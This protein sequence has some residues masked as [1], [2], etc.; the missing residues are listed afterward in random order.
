MRGP[1]PRK[2]T[3]PVVAP[4]T[5][6]SLVWRSVA[7]SEMPGVNM[8]EASGERTYF[9]GK[10]DADGD[11]CAEPLLTGHESYDCY[12]YEFTSARPIP[13][14]LVIFFGEVDDLGLIRCRFLRYVWLELY[15]RFILLVFSVTVL[16]QG[17][18]F[19]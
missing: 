17:R 14:V 10:L 2:T 1:M 16:E 13:W 18:A 9:P 8:L 7:I 19:I 5:V 4:T 3:K 11:G 6:L 15:L 12:I